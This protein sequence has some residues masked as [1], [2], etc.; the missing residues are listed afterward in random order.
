[1]SFSDRDV[2]YVQNPA[3]GAALLWGFVCGYYSN[4]NGP[5]PFPIFQRSHEN[6]MDDVNALCDAVEQIES[7]TREM[8]VV[9][10]AFEREMQIVQEQ[11][12]EQTDKLEAIQNRIKAESQSL[13][14]PREESYKFE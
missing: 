10:A 4:E 7:T 12:Q 2:M 1:M 3:I 11:I 14:I 13:A 5:V 8:D 6:V 9:P